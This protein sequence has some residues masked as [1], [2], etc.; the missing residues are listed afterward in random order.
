MRRE[1]VCDA[2]AC[3]C[4]QPLPSEYAVRHPSSSFPPILAAKM[5]ANPESMLSGGMSCMSR[6]SVGLG[7]NSNSLDGL[8][9]LGLN[10][11][12]YAGVIVGYIRVCKLKVYRAAKIN[13]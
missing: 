10:S 3:C 2:A 6:S 8:D 9:G 1:V 7:L 5:P 4:W 11:P 12:G 13:K